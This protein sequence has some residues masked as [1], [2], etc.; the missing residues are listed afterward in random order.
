[1]ETIQTEV[2]QTAGHGL[3]IDQHMLFGKCSHAG[4]RTIQRSVLELVDL[5]IGAGEVDDAS[6][7]IAQ[8]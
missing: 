4:A 5:A 8:V 2:E 6:Y 1:V 3:A 7:R